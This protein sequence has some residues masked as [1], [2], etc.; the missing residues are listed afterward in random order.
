MTRGQGRKRTERVP[1]P[2][3]SGPYD[4]LP[5]PLTFYL[6]AGERRAVLEKLG[7]GKGPRARRLLRA[8]GIAATR[9]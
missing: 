1:E 8:L 9:C 5:H 7:P 4:E 3:P 2:S 6:T